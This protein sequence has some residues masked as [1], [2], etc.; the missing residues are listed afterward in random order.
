M[1]REEKLHQMKSSLIAIL[2][3]G[4]AMFA[5]AGDVRGDEPVTIR[6]A[7][8]NTPASLI[9]ILFAK[10]GLAQ[11]QG[12]SY[13]FEPVYYASSPT[14]ISAIASGELEIA[15]L[16]FIS[17]P[18]AVLNAG[19]TDLRV[20]ADET[21]AG[22][23]GHATVEYAVLKDSP[24]KTID[25]LKG[26]TLATIGIGSGTDIAMRATLVKH[27]LEFPRDY[28][29]VEA[30]PAVAVPMLLDHK[31]DMIFNTV[32]F[33]YL[34]DYVNNSRVLFTMGDGMG[35]AELSVWLARA[36]F[37]EKHRA[38]MVDLMEDMIRSYRWYADPANH[39][40]AVAIL[41]RTTKQPAEQLDGWAFT[42][43]D[44]GRNLDGVPDIAMLQRNIDTVQSLGFIKSHVDVASLADLSLVKEAG[45]RL[46]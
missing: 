3:A 9:P 15:T 17:I 32:P 26:K 25:D 44:F 5:S 13:R 27:G 40:E 22:V 14:Q 20:I 7:W 45:Q 24:I 16:N 37:I 28:T 43:K 1:L 23:E 39:K 36:G 29:I 19:L 46:K 38:A 42:N 31:A 34:P 12:K 2:L 8:V 21:Q 4:A 11:H 33:T 30:R 6:A 10:D 18:S 41:A 35:G